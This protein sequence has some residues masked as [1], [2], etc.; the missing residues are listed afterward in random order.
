MFQLAEQI[1][2]SIFPPNVMEWVGDKTEIGTPEV[3]FKSTDTYIIIDFHTQPCR[4]AELYT[5]PGRATGTDHGVGGAHR[6]EPIHMPLE[7]H[8]PRLPK[9]SSGP[10]SM[11]GT[12]E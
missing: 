10:L 9:V 5:A 7:E 3:F 4:V 1:G 12:G 8:L 11:M 2:K 6:D